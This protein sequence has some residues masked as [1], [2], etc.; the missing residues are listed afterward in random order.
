MAACLSVLTEHLEP[1]LMQAFQAFDRAGNGWL[2]RQDLKGL[3]QSESFNA[4]ASPS[5]ATHAI[6]TVLKAGECIRHSIQT[7]KV[8]YT[9]YVESKSVLD[10][11]SSV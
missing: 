1:Q 2:T 5:P 4:T 9:L 7:Q 3:L 8:S 11:P 10:T 6:L